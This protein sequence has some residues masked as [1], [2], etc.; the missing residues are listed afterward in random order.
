[1]KCGNAECSN[2]V[3]TEGDYLCQECVGKALHAY[4]QPSLRQ[5]ADV[6]VSELLQGKQPS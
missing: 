6:A 1:M 3:Q 4:R 2:Q 5:L